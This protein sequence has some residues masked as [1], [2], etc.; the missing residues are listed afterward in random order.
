MKNFDEILWLEL[1]KHINRESPLPT[2]SL[3]SDAMLAL[4]T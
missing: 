1:G 3:L 4:P 2:G